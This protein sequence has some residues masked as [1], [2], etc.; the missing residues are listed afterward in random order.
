L[1]GEADVIGS[2]HVLQAEVLGSRIPDARY[3]VLKGQSHGF[4]WQA[5]ADTN[6]RILEWVRAHP[7]GDAARVESSAA[8]V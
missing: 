1:I 6:A 7:G 4:F 3:E 2:N 5:P 8:L